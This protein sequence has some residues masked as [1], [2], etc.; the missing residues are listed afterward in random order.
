M[1]HIIEELT[2]HDPTILKIFLANEKAKLQALLRESE[3]MFGQPRCLRFCKYQP[4]P[5]GKTHILR[6]CCR[7][8]MLVF[9]TDSEP[10]KP[11]FRLQNLGLCTVFACD[12]ARPGL[13]LLRFRVD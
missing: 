4:L 3:W 8:R 10:T 7:S 12:V 13:C 6:L 2:S 9:A 5:Q 1:T 11:D